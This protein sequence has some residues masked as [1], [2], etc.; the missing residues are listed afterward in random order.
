ATRNPAKIRTLRLVL[1]HSSHF[2]T[3]TTGYHLFQ[4][5][6]PY[7]THRG[8]GVKLTWDGSASMSAYDPKRTLPLRR[9]GTGPNQRRP[10]HDPLECFV[11]CGAAALLD[12]GECW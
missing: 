8:R 4:Y 9:F 3:E 12:F 11:L 6:Q 10:A 5:L 1:G 7:P 2:I